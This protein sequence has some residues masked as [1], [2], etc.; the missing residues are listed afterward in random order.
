MSPPLFKSVFERVMSSTP[1]GSLGRRRRRHQVLVLAYH[2]VVPD[3][4]VGQGDLSLHLGFKQF[5]AQLDELERTHQ[6]IALTDAFGVAAGRPR[7]VLTF[8]DA[9]R[10]A[11]ELALP[12]LA[13][14]GLPATVFVATGL[15]GCGPP[16][17]DRFAPL[18]TE[19]EAP[20]RS[21]LLV[22][23]EG[24]DLSVTA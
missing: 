20:V 16:W 17:W 11:V 8:D 22:E 4:E 23:C 2:N 14:R 24:R 5:V 21:K 7:A 15:L 13:R 3:D 1:I 10:G 19:W 9:Y 6:V 18:A 12:E